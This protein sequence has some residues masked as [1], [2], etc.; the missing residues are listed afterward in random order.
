MYQH[1][2][3][4]KKLLEQLRYLIGY[5]TYIISAGRNV[6]PCKAVGQVISPSGET[7]IQYTILGKRDVHS[8]PLKT[9]MNDKALLNKFTPTQAAK[10][11]VISIGEIL[12]TLPESERKNR[13]EEIR[14]KMLNK[15]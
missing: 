12:F 14:S 13:F 1:P 15:Q 4:F 2:A 11:G 7:I 10:L 8:I 6:Y 3:I 5:I 9:L